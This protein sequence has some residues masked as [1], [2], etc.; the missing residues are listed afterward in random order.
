MFL[1][2]APGWPCTRVNRAPARESADSDRAP[3]E[4]RPSH[5]ATRA[6]GLVIAPAAM[7]VART[8]RRSSDADENDSWDRSVAS[9]TN[10]LVTRFAEG[11]ARANARRVDPA[12]ARAS[13]LLSA[14]WRGRS[15]SARS[16]ERRLA[17]PRSRGP[18][19]SR[20]LASA[21]DRRP[22]ASQIDAYETR[23]FVAS[24]PIRVPSRVGA[25]DRSRRFGAPRAGDHARVIARVVGA[26]GSTSDAPR[27]RDR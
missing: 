27:A 18:A 22:R 20:Q 26:R 25:D 5:Q 3:V 16:T 6:R 19:L 4:T 24:A 10:A 21:T 9:G 1:F 14:V 11:R 12:R 7:C 23:A 15:S 2:D 8:D 13:R 17:L